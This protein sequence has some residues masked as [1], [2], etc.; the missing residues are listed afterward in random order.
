MAFGQDFLKGF[1]GVENLRDYSHASKTFTSNGYELA[2]RNKFLFH[3]FFNINTGEIPALK[4][5]F[6]NN[7]IN[8]LSLLVKTVQLP[9]FTV[10]TET[11][12]QYNR[13]RV[14]QKKINYQPIQIDFHDDG[15]DL[16]RNMWY[17]YYSYYYKDSANQY[18]PPSSNGSIGDVANPPGFSYPVRDIYAA[19]RYVNDWGYIGES[20]NQGNAGGP[21][22]GSGGD[23][24]TGKPPFFRDITIYGLNQHKFAAYTLINPLIKEWRGDTYDYTQGNGIMQNTMVVEFET[25]KFYTGAIGK[26]RPDTNVQG[27]ADPNR[28]DTV[29]SPIAR[30]GSQSTV[31]GQGGLLDAGIGIISDLQ[32]GNL[33]GI[34]GAVQK[35]GTTYNTFKGKNLRSVVNEEAKAALKGVLQTSL[36]GAVRQ[37]QNGSGGFIFPQSPTGPR[38]R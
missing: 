24:T 22:T 4:S 14:I 10:D 33:A 18:G 9:T 6:P 32:S 17:N 8:S 5:L 3:V 27:F 29:R 23:Q 28:Y 25:V 11:L 16:G 21:G 26:S 37:A 1:F 13:K 12:N 2:P 36:P 19:N 35:A 30:P 15:S 7:D 20:F 38:G 31:L 34:I